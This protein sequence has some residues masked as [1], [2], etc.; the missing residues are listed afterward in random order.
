MGMGAQ[1]CMRIYGGGVDTLASPW[2]Q[3]LDLSPE[4]LPEPPSISQQP[5]R[6]S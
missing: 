2:P 5:Q 3:L 1:M 4:A 6:E